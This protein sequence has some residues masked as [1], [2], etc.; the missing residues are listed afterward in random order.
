[1]MRNA[2][3]TVNNIVG[4]GSDQSS[5]GYIQVVPKLNKEKFTLL[6]INV[7]QFWKPLQENSGASVVIFG[8]IQLLF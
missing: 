2:D 8:T 5:I 3:P 6:I 4:P 7:N 1:M